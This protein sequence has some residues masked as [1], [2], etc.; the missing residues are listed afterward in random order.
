MLKQSRWV[1]VHE[2]GQANFDEKENVMDI[3]LGDKRC[4]AEVLYTV[5][6]YRK[7]AYWL[8]KYLECAEAKALAAMIAEQINAA[9]SE[10]NRE[11]PEVAVSGDDWNCEIER[12]SAMAFRTK[13][14]WQTDEPVQPTPTR[15]SRT[16]K[17]AQLAAQN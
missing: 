4:R 5:R 11:S 8:L 1:K 7:A 13:L 2:P 15:R 10:A 6:S 16:R 14:T 3:V 9:M 17:A 12:M